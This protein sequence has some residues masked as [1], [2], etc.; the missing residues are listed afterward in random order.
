MHQSH[1]IKH[2]FQPAQF[3][4]LHHKIFSWKYYDKLNDKYISFFEVVKFIVFPSQSDR[5]VC[6]AA[7]CV[8]LS[9][10]VTQLL[11]FLI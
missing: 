2:T 9:T 1:S 8:T 5:L 10:N 6:N 11:L 3:D 7:V 4:I